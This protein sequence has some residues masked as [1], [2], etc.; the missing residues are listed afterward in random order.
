M[1]WASTQASMAGGRRQRLR[2]RRRLSQRTLRRCLGGGNKPSSLE[3][4]HSSAA[5]LVEVR[6]SMAA[7]LAIHAPI[8]TVAM[9]VV[10]ENGRP[11]EKLGHITFVTS[12]N[13][14]S[15]GDPWPV[16]LTV[17]S[18]IL[19]FQANRLISPW[20]TLIKLFTSTGPMRA[21]RCNCNKSSASKQ[22]AHIRVVHPCPN[23]PSP[24]R[25]YSPR[26]P[27]ILKPASQIPRLLFIKAIHD[28]MDVKN[29]IWPSESQCV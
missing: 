6:E 22:G 24:E 25:T 26:K 23:F 28:T 15:I 7:K 16:Q 29:R 18:V 4:K 9:L 10:E 12:N 17:C 27:I 14:M 19:H 11:G 21:L 1:F 13:R 3:T 5:S 8:Y 20:L 2:R